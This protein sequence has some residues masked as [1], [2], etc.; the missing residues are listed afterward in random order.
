MI[1]YPKQWWWWGASISIWE[2]AAGVCGEEFRWY[3]Y[4][5]FGQALQVQRGFCL[6]QQIYLGNDGLNEGVIQP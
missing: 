6:L 3:G 5:A 2:D 1:C 4:V